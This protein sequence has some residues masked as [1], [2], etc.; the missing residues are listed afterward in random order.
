MLLIQE[1]GHLIDYRSQ[2]MLTTA[3]DYVLDPTGK[4]KISRMFSGPKNSREVLSILY[5]VGRDRQMERNL[6]AG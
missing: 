4:F 5:I 6:R 3:I 2:V 1:P